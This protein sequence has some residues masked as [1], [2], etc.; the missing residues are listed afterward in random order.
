MNH[1]VDSPFKESV[2]DSSPL[3]LT[4][5]LSNLFN[6]FSHWFNNPHSVAM[7]Q[8]SNAGVVKNFFSIM[9]NKEIFRRSSSSEFEKENRRLP[10]VNKTKNS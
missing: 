3:S 1:I 7:G 4:G 5:G 10:Q 8:N 9:Q 2:C 6:M